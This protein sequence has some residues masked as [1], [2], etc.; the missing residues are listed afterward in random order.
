MQRMAFRPIVVILVWLVVVSATGMLIVA[1]PAAK[2]GSPA[3]AVHSEARAPAPSSITPFFPN[4]DI[5]DHST[6]YAW[7]VEPTMVINRS[8]TIFVGWKETNGPDAAGL[9]VGASYSV[10]HGQTWATN[11][12]MNQSHPNQS[13]ANSDPWMALT[14][15]DRVNYAYLEFNCAGANSGLDVSNTT[16]GNWGTVH[17]VVGKGGL[18]D[19]DS[20]AV[21]STGRLYAAWDEGNILALTWSDDGGKTW[22]P[23]ENPGGVGDSVLGAIVATHGNSTVYLTYWDISTSNIMFMSSANRGGTWTSP[24]RVN[25]Q[26][27]SA[28]E[29]GSWQIPDP[30]MNVDPASGEIYIA[31]PDVRNR[32]QDI[33]FANSTDGGQTWGTNHKINDDIGSAS[34]W[35]VDLAVD[36]TGRVHAAWEDARTG[37]LNIFYANSTD[38]GQTWTAN[39]RVTSAETPISYDR[40]GDYFA[41]E[42]GSDNTIYVVWTDGRGKDFDIYYARNPGFP[43]A[44][45]TVDTRPTGLTVKVD[46]VSGKAPVTNTWILGSEH[47]VSVAST[48]PINPGSRYNWT[49]WSDGGAP[50][51]T[52]NATADM[53]IAASFQKQYSAQATTNPSGLTIL[54]DNVSYASTYSIWWDANSTH[55]IEAPSPQYTSSDVRYAWASWNDSGTE[56]HAVI[57]NAPKNLVANYLQEQDLLISTSPDGLNFTFDGANYSRTE[58]FW[59]SP[60]SYHTVSLATLQSGPTGVRYRFAQ[61]S[62]GGAAT[63]AIHFT[64]AEALQAVFSAEFYLTVNSP[65][66]GVSGSGWYANGSRVTVTATYSVYATSPGEQLV[67]SGWGGNAN[68]SGLTSNPILMDGPKTAVALYGAEFYL[69]VVSAYGQASGSGWYAEGSSATAVVSPTTVSIGG[70]TRAAFSGWSGDSTGSSTTSNPILMDGPKTAKATWQVQYSLAIV[71]TY[72]VAVNAGWY[73]AGTSA[74][75]G[76]QSGMVDLGPGSR[77]AFAGWSGDASGTDATASNP[78]LMSRPKTAIAQWQR[79]YLVTVESDV[80][81]VQGAGWYAENATVTVQASAQVVQGGATYTF[82]GWTGD[83]SGSSSS[84][85]FTSSRPVTIRAVWTTATAV[86]S[87]MVLIGS[88]AAV[89]IIVLVAVLVVWMR[90]RKKQEPKEP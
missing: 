5:I 51:H 30:A 50:T 42:A 37:N 56:A 69:D 52:I 60:D 83:L 76:L 67:F 31:W 90:R 85:T 84:L 24:V 19:K 23:I 28:Q 58:T 55:W 18:V 59:L 39:I 77:A 3:L 75:A 81:G 36:G 45:V 17:F 47:T 88:A 8:G 53:T 54:V 10:D 65:V 74:T 48:I 4:I 46:G 63:H 41:L 9:R 34:Q 22:A 27:G 26:D 1:S 73:D 89:V 6:P 66:P 40:P 78:I 79:Q 13:C 62:D 12:L 16:D 64:A 15:D 86:G 68:G 49:S 70:G 44:T 43:A 38:G 20:I 14:P 2:A 35:M 80:G 87:D 72:G 11:I 29:V 82:A 61:W 33:Y 21:D 25:S 57:A 71:T 32:N 7:Q